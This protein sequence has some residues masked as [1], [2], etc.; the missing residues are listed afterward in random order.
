MSANIYCGIKEIPKNAKRGSMRECA[1][2][3]QIRYWGLKKVDS[4]VLENVEQLMSL[5]KARL[6]RTKFDTRL[7]RLTTQYNRTKDKEK[8][9]I[10]KKEITETEKELKKATK[11]YEEAYFS[12]KR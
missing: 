10:L 8:K 6:N 5:D 1:E 3:N 9:L 11:I 12:K 4:R 7:K 2:K